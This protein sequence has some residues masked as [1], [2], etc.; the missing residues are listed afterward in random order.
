MSRSAA[1]VYD[2]RMLRVAW[3]VLLLS[4][5]P[6][7]QAP[8]LTP[9]PPIEATPAAVSHDRS[10]LLDTDRRD[11][12]CR[13]DADCT[14]YLFGWCHSHVGTCFYATCASKM[15]RDPGPPPRPT[16]LHPVLR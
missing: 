8:H 5:G 11:H 10:Q 1:R 9:A 6:R 4:C 16:T 15:C 3:L 13:R 12:R 14:D 2:G 7:A